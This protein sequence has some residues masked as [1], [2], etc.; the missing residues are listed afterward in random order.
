MAL[1]LVSSLATHAGSPR[2]ELIELAMIRARFSE[3]LMQ[4]LGRRSEC[5]PCFVTGLFSLLDALLQVPM[6]ELVERI[7]LTPELKEA[8]LSR[9]G[10]FG[11]VL[12]LAEAYEDARWSEVFV[13]AGSLHAALDIL[14]ALYVEAVEWARAATRPAAATG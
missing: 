7:S 9:R 2:D 14:P 4:S 13:H 6:P 1:L 8:L 3:L 5:A 12:R 11:T 10:A